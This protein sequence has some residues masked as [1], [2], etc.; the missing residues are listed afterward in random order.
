MGAEINLRYRIL[1]LDG[2]V[3]TF[4]ES[5]E[6]TLI[7]GEVQCEVTGGTLVLEN[8]A[9]A[10]TIC[11]RDGIPDPCNVILT[12]TT[13]TDPSTY[14]V[15]CSAGV[16]LGTPAGHPSHF[17]RRVGGA[18]TPLASHR[19]APLTGTLQHRSF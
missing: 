15:V 1:S 9:T 19:P 16:I 17:D 10:A 11:G 5:R 6:I 7:I 12:D 14:L 18:R 2:S 3:S 13:G 8:G 4:G